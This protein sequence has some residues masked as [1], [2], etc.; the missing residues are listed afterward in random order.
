LEQSDK[1]IQRENEERYGRKTTTHTLSPH[2]NHVSHGDIL[3]LT[4]SGD[5][6]DD[7]LTVVA[8]NN[9]DATTV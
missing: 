5:Q 3:P 8:K 2:C 6:D 7:V 1:I 4:S 9:N